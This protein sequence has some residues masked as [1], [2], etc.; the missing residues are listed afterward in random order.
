MSRLA[1]DGVRASAPE[2]KSPRW[3]AHMLGAGVPRL[4]IE[5]RLHRPAR[6]EYL[7]GCRVAL[8]VPIFETARP[9]AG[10]RRR[11]AVRI[12]LTARIR[13]FRL[14][15]LVDHGRQRGNR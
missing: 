13:C 10:R 14:I 11:G 3:V 9:M 5:A 1:L 4:K 6:V 15:H 2:Y 8:A 12:E 7:L